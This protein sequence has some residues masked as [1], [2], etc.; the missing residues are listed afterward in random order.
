MINPNTAIGISPPRSTA[1]SGFHCRMRLSAVQIA[2]R[3]KMRRKKKAIYHSPRNIIIRDEIPSAV[4]PSVLPVRT[5]IRTR[6]MGVII[7]PMMGMK[8][9]DTN[10]SRV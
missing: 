3:P 5:V 4:R 10:K 2:I 6:G 1:V 9:P 8:N 7:H